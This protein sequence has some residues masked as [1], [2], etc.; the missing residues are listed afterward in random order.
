M[1]AVILIL[2]GVARASDYASFTPEQ[3]FVAK[4]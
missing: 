2:L 4:A 3:R 1:I